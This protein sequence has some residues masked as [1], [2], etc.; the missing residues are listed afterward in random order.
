M[1]PGV[2]DLLR[3]LPPERWTIVTSCTQRLLVARLRAAGLPEPPNIVSADD[4]IK[5]KPDP[6]PYRRGAELLGFAPEDCIVVEDA[7]SGV[8]AGR[9]AG[10]RV[11]AVLS[12]TPAHELQAATWIA[13]SLEGVRASRSP[14]G[15]TVNIPS[16]V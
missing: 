16:L 1:L 6:E 8:A 10:C 2:T 4:V 7:A 3:S 12:S 14:Q 15:L 13:E 5:G 9:A 11:L